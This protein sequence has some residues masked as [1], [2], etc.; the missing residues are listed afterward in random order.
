VLENWSV[1]KAKISL[2]ATEKVHGGTFSATCL[3]QNKRVNLPQPEFPLKAV[4]WCIL[5]GITRVNAGLK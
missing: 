2:H 1:A 3:P 4:E 5:F